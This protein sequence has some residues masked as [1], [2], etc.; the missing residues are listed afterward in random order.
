MDEIGIGEAL[1]AVAGIVDDV[2]DCIEVGALGR[3]VA[4]ATEQH[5]S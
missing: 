4:P 3:A 5:P 1:V 2:Q